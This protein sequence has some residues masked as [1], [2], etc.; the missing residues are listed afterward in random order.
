MKKN[1][2]ELVNHWILFFDRWIGMNEW[3]DEK[4]SN[5]P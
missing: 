4:K 5:N 3:C 2:N 1:D